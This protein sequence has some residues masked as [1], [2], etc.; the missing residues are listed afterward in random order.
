MWRNGEITEASAYPPH[1]MVAIPTTV[2]QEGQPGSED[3]PAADTV[4]AGIGV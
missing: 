1:R 4:P 3:F 2:R